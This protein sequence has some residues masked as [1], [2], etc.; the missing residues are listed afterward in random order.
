MKLIFTLIATT[1]SLSAFAQS[2]KVCTVME[3]KREARNFLWAE[4]V[5]QVRLLEKNG[6]LDKEIN[7]VLSDKKTERNIITEREAI[8][9]ILA[10]LKQGEMAGY[11]K[12]ISTDT[13]G[14]I[15]PEQEDGIL[16]YEAD[17]KRAHPIEG[18]FD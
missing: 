14:C 11:M 4:S 18:L 17:L 5:H 15:E 9:D 10:S 6:C 3:L 1:L 2:Q 12:C 13:P 7:K 16:E 8:F